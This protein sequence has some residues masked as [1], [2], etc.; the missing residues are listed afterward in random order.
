MNFNPTLFSQFLHNF[1]KKIIFR[2]QGS[3]DDIKPRFMVQP[4]TRPGTGPELPR[5]T[6]VIQARKSNNNYDSLKWISSKTY[7]I[8]HIGQLVGYQQILVYIHMRNHHRG[9]RRLI[10]NR[11]YDFGWNIHQYLK[12]MTLVFN[13]RNSVGTFWRPYILLSSILIFLPEHPFPL[14]LPSPSYPAPH[15]HS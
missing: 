6:E 3:C 5:P 15:E 14:T 8:L 2:Q 7:L 11:S 4:Y 13:L 9:W 1:H 10:E 12:S